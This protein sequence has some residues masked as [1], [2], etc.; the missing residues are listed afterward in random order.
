LGPLLFI[1]FLNDFC[2]LNLHS[3]ITLFADDTTLFNSDANTTEVLAKLEADLVL[4]N[5]WLWNNRLVLNVKKTLAIHFPPTASPTNLNLYTTLDLSLNNEKIKFV[6]S[7]KTLGVTFDNQLK[8]SIHTRNVC[9]LINTKTYLLS[10]SISLFTN[11]FRPTLFKL[12]IQPHFDYCSTIYM[13]LANETDRERLSKCF[14]KSIQRLVNVN[15]FGLTLEQQHGILRPFKILPLYYR[16]FFRFCIFLFKLKRKNSP[17]L[18]LKENTFCTRSRFILPTFY[19][20]FKRFAFCTISTR[21]LNSFMDEKHLNLSE[22]ELKTTLNDN[23]PK[24]Y[25]DSIGYWQ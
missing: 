8:F 21:L 9:K 3:E 11:K 1:I 18:T 4:I 6:T 16:Q 17:I 2:H 7:T 13:Y 22:N 5:K 12:F 25:N 19:T 24:L 10:K 15:T 14:S 20:H 23:L